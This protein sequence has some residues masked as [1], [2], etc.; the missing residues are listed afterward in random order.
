MITKKILG[1]IALAIITVIVSVA[2]GE[3]PTDAEV[4]AST[5]LQSPVVAAPEKSGTLNTDLSAWNT[6]QSFDIGE[7]SIPE[8]PPAIEETKKQGAKSDLVG[9]WSGQYVTFW[10]DAEGNLNFNNVDMEGKL[11]YNATYAGYNGKIAESFEYPYSIELTFT[12][13]ASWG[14]APKSEKGTFTFNSPTSGY[15]TGYAVQ[16]LGSYPYGWTRIS[17]KEGNVKKTSSSPY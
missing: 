10:I 12:P 4:T 8:P 14:L 15:F 1:L 11:G 9:T 17:D 2:C 7:V 3:K 13:P 6:K 16:K 5:E